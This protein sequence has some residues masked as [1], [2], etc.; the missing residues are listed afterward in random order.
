[1]LFK[2]KIN[3]MRRLFMHSL[4]RTIGQKDDIIGMNNL[5]IVNV[6]ICRPNSRLGNQLLTTPIIQDI[7]SYFPN[8]KIDVFVR[9]SAAC[10]ILKLSEFDRFIR[11]PQKPFAILFNILCLV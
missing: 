3:G 1:M 2:G 7:S 8:C 10:A 4:I 9:G 5:D 6:L 11:Q